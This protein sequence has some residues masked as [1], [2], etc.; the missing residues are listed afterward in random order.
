MHWILRH[1]DLKLML[2]NTSVVR[3]TI[4]HTIRDKL[5]NSGSSNVQQCNDLQNETIACMNGLCRAELGAFDNPEDPVP[6]YRTYCNHSPLEDPFQ[7]KTGFFDV[8]P[9]G[10]PPPGE[11]MHNFY[12]VCNQN[13][14][15]NQ[16]TVNVIQKLIHDYNT[17]ELQGQGFLQPCPLSMYFG[18][19]M[20]S[21][22]VFHRN[23]TEP[24]L[25]LDRASKGCEL[26]LTLKIFP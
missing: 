6:F 8:V 23:S 26:L 13:L 2:K 12:Y 22:T 17:N 25:G 10:Y 21:Q 14:C 4:L 19:M 1:P 7:N 5:Y 24:N 9:H 15:K 20:P 11:N 16:E 3:E 18:V